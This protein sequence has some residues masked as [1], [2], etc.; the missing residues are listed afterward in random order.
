MLRV[1]LN[2]DMGESFGVYSL[3]RD[4]EIMGRV[5]SVNIACGFHAGDPTVM[6]KTAELAIRKKVAIGAHPG[7]PDLQGFGRRTIQMQPEE[8]YDMILYQ[9]GALQAIVQSQGARLHHVKPHG[10]LYNMAARDPLLASA[11]AKAV[12]DCDKELIL[13]GLA[14]STM[15]T[16]AE[17]A[18]LRAAHEVFADRTYQEDGT[19]TPRTSPAALITDPAKA[20]LQVLGMV[21]NRAITTASGNRI[22]VQPDTVCIHGDGVGAVE[23][24]IA[25]QNLFQ[26]HNIRIEP[27]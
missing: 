25:I 13:V 6:R 19:L 2:C 18:G 3:G 5:S 12:R 23:I 14:G 21:Q 8:V 26:Q 11:I 7:Y 16:E 27:L 22:P 20:A 4:A 24:S 9:V 10:A 1:D 15:I 17:K